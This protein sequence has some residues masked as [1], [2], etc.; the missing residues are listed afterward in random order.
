MLKLK[1]VA[2]RSIEYGVEK[3]RYQG[4]IEYFGERGK[5]SLTLSHADCERLLPV[6]GEA[7]VASSRQVAE[8][9]T[10]EAVQSLPS[11][12]LKIG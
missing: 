5:V 12:E 1:S 3:G 2:I 7:I 4:E 9:L 10:A 6:V 8:T 11:P